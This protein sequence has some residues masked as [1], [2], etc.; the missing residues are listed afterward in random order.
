MAWQRT[1]LGVAGVSALLLHDTGGRV[2]PAL[3]GLFGLTMAVVLLVLSELRY[4]HTV[5]QPGAGTGP[6]QTHLL[7]LLAGTVALLAAM[8]IWLSLVQG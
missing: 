3:P 6:A 5:S 4:E 7:L 8:A 2:V 1:A